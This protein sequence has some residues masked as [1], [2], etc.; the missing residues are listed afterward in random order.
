[1]Q[2]DRVKKSGWKKEWNNYF[3]LEREDGL[4]IIDF[5]LNHVVLFYSGCEFQAH[6]NR[7]FSRLKN[8][9]AFLPCRTANVDKKPASVHVLEATVTERGA[10]STGHPVRGFKI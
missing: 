6:Q 8:D 5:S 3:E 2:S 1:M 7:T 4:K 9:S 10:S